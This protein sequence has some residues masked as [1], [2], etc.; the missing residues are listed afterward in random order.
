[1][2]RTTFDDL[3]AFTAVADERSFVRAAIKLGLSASALSHAM[4]ALETRLGVRLLARTTRSVATTD[5]GERLLQTL[6]PAFADIGRELQALGQLRGA[7]SGTI[8]ITTFKHAATSVLMPV[9]PAFL[10]E[11]P[12]VRLELDL[13]D[14]L[15]DIVARRY[16]AGIRWPEMVHRDMVAV[17]VGRPVRLAVV[18]APGY[19]AKHPMPRT[20]RDLTKHRCVNYRNPGSGRISP[21]EFARGGRALQ[22]KV[23]G[24]LVVSDGEL[25]IRAA[26]D[27]L[28]LTMYYEDELAP[29]V[30]AGRLVRVLTA[31]CPPYPGYQ[32]YYPSRRHVPPALAAL[33]A[34]LRK[35]LLPAHR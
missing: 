1:M 28:G 24:S 4:K 35:R 25:G 26:L 6:R 21:W 2:A 12:D 29:H 20:P 27:G 16:D 5:A 10:A 3:Q 7:P 18:G 23:E 34:A 9:L 11:H 8:R 14:G 31:W 13:D 32:L 15:V 33:V 30:E 22:T 17:T 19:F